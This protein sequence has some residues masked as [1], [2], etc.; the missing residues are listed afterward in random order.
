MQQLLKI[1]FKATPTL[2]PKLKDAA[3]VIL[4]NPNLVATTSMRAL[5]KQ[6]GVTPPTMIRLAN[7]LGFESYEKFKRVFQNS[8]NDQ[9]FENRASWL[10]HS[11]KK[12]GLTSVIHE[13][14]ESGHSNIQH[15]YQNLDLKKICK[16]AD[17]I[18]NAKTAYVVAAGG[19]H[20]MAAYMQYVG[21]MAVPHLRV[22]R[23]SGHGL[24]EGLIPIDENDTILTIAHHPYSKQSIDA[25]QFALDRGAHMIYLT[26]SLAA[27]LAAKAEVLLLQKTDSPQFFPSMVSVVST[28]ETLIA[29]II[30]RS[31]EKGINAISDYVELRK[32]SGFS[33]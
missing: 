23:T 32:E 26:D 1:L 7:E 21:N 33:I 3:K 12:D 24:A 13:L 16:A 28:I 5:A 25:S 2:T 9:N 18:I 11:T 20:W 6:A 8:I 31:G 4:D 10:Q 15:F 29:I 30:A 27:P 22:P 19:A 14:A 17:L